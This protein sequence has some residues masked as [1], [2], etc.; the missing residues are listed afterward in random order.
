MGAQDGSKPRGGEG[1]A[2]EAARN[3]RPTIAPPFDPEAFARDSES[4]L[5]TAPPPQ[6]SAPTVRGGAPE[7]TSEM[8]PIA[9]S[10]PELEE[11]GVGDL[12][13]ALGDDTV[14]VVIASP[15]ELGWLDL[16][17]EAERLLAHING[18]STF[19]RICA[20]ANVTSEEGAFIVLDL[21]EQGIISFR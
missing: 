4:R 12:R 11:A 18:V 8:R 16:P 13:D 19:E 7:R 1:R 14:P 21:A 17:P 9:A 6:S 10:G 15:D 20:K 2:A 5:S 3:D